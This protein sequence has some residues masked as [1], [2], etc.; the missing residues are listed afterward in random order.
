MSLT[1]VAAAECPFKLW[2]TYKGTEI[3]HHKTL[4]AYA[5]VTRHNAVDADGA[6]NAYHPGDV[7]KNCLKDAHLGL[8]CPGNAGYPKTDWWDQV[9]VVDPAN[10]QKPYVQPSG[11]FAGFFVTKT[12]LSDPQ[13]AATDPGKY[14]DSTKVPYIVFPGSKFAVLKGTGDKGD[15]G[16]ALNRDTGKS[17]SFIVADK[18]GGS[19]AKLGEASISFFEALGGENINARNGDGVAEGNTLFVVFPHSRKAS[20]PIW[21]RTN[22]DVSAQVDTLMKALGGDR[23]VLKACGF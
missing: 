8:D 10:A 16:F 18:G 21:P 13:K 22:E 23:D 6:P 19:D 2:R 4:G 17:T 3:Y 20:S 12:W 14:V 15:V 1:P 7:G 5:Y 11:E 9:L